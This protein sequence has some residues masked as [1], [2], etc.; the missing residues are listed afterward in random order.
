MSHAVAVSEAVASIGA[1]ALALYTEHAP[2]KLARL[3]VAVTALL[4]V[5]RYA[6][7]PKHVQPHFLFRQLSN[8]LPPTV[9]FFAA[10][11][12]LL[13]AHDP[14]T[15]QLMDSELIAMVTVLVLALASYYTKSEVYSMTAQL[16]A[17]LGLTAVTAW[18]FATH[19]AHA[20]QTVLATMLGLFVLREAALRRLLPS[21]LAEPA[22]RYALVVTLAL[23]EAAW[24]VG[25]ANVA[26]WQA[27]FAS[28]A[29]RRE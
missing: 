15:Q 22:R 2:T 27:A 28:A 14:L 8:A 23:G 26:A 16:A 7:T 4:G 12:R 6:P 24:V 25:A 5:W 10:A 17:F 1:A 21:H 9:T 13:P 20:P 19:G 3:L 29:A 18:A 11:G